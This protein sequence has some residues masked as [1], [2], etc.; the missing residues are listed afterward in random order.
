MKFKGTV[1][2]AAAF[3]GIVLYYYLIDIP[4]EKKQSL[5]KERAEKILL[6]E[7]GRVEEFILG[8]KDATFHL[9]RKGPDNWELLKPVRAKAD[10]HTASSF[11]SLLQSARFSSIQRING[12]AARNR[13]PPTSRL[14]TAMVRTSSP[15]IRRNDSRSPCLRN[16]PGVKWTG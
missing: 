2:M 3:L 14:S 10:T 12:A 15:A 1:W 9:K 16:R 6:F 7:T 8:K 13:N 5:E 11:L 4:A